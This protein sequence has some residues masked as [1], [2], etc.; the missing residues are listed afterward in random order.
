MDL[1]P[2]VFDFADAAEPAIAD[3]STFTSE[4]QGLSALTPPRYVVRRMCEQLVTEK[5]AF[6]FSLTRSGGCAHAAA[7]RP[8]FSYTPISAADR[9]GP[10]RIT[11]SACCYC[12]GIRSECSPGLAAAADYPVGPCVQVA[13]QICFKVHVVKQA[14][15][16]LPACLAVPAGP[17]GLMRWRSD[18]RDTGDILSLPTGNHCFSQPWCGY[19]VSVI[20]RPGNSSFS[21]P[22]H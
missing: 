14:G 12:A 11:S 13:Y 1:R 18:S 10:M 8:A 6:C 5:V 7:W 4:S 16:W 17:G 22:V 19:Y 3:L 21:M 9:A 2:G 15:G 20:R